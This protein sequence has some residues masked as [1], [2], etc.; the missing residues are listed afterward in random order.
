MTK[1]CLIL[2]SDNKYKLSTLEF[3]K[4]GSLMVVINNHFNQKYLMLLRDSTLRIIKLDNIPYKLNESCEM[5][6]R[7]LF[8]AHLCV[9][10]S[11]WNDILPNNNLN[12]N[13]LKFNLKFKLLTHHWH[14]LNSCLSNPISNWI[15]EKLHCITLHFIAFQPVI[16]DFRWRFQIENSNERK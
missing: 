12:L 1:S 9:S 2:D 15:N 8:D 6:F 13:F 7:R 10:V 14:D 5:N 16:N 3:W 4:D 11:P